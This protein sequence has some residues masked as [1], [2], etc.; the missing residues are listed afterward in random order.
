VPPRAG[1]GIHARDLCLSPRRSFRSVRFSISRHRV[2]ST[3]SCVAILPVR[4]RQSRDPGPPRG[5]SSCPTPGSPPARQSS[6]AS[7]QRS[8]DR[9]RKRPRRPGQA[10][11]LSTSA[12]PSWSSARVLL[13]GPT[14]KV[15][16][17][18]S[19]ELKVT[20][21]SSRGALWREGLECATVFMADVNFPRPASVF[22]NTLC[23]V[24]DL[25]LLAERGQNLFVGPHPPPTK[26]VRTGGRSATGDEPI[27]LQGPAASP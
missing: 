12:K 14:I 3:I 26:R 16:R 24:P 25:G 19:A 10:N 13:L 18:Y 22:C 5:C 20:M 23:S 9:R 1:Q 8:P 21:K 17:R 11:V 6:P 15:A 27:D 2:P 7:L 4:Q